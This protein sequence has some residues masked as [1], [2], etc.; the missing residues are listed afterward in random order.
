MGTD[1]IRSP[2]LLTNLIRTRE[3][4]L[5]ENRRIDELHI[6][7]SVIALVPESVARENTILPVD[8][9]GETLTCVTDRDTDV[10]LQDKLRFILNCNVR[11]LF[12]DRTDVIAGIVRYYGRASMTSAESYLQEFTDTAIDFTETAMDD[13]PMLADCLSDRLPVTAEVLRSRFSSL[14]QNVQVSPAIS[15]DG[16]MFYTIAEGQRILAHRR[17]GKVDVLQGPARVWKGFTRFERMRHY[18]AHPRQYLAIRFRD[19]REE[20]QLGPAELW[21]DPREHESIETHECLDLAAKE[22]VVVYNTPASDIDS[23]QTTRRIFYGPAQFAP[24]PGEWLHRFSWHAARGG[25]RGE[26]K[27]PDGLQF[28]KLCLMPD[29]MY[30]DVHDVR[31]ADD[32]VLT[33][34]LMIFFELVDIDRMLDTTHD[35]IGDFINA[36]TSDVVEFTGKRSF[37]SFK[38]HTEQ[39]N[40]LATYSQL[41][42]RAQ[43]CGYKINNVVYR[44]YGA[45]SSLQTMHDEAIQSRTRLRLERATE[46]Q[47][48]DVEDYKLTCQMERAE[49]RRSEQMTEVNHDLELKRQQHAADLQQRELEQDFQRDQRRSQQELELE[50]QQR[51]DEQKQSHLNSLR[52]LQVDL[53]EYLTQSRADQVIEVRGNANLTPEL[54]LANGKQ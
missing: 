51:Q 50:L 24:R 36:A 27:R 31:T 5:P 26:E 48:Q 47:A 46:E 42:H 52:E 12:S 53:T 16:F 41:L 10:M 4:R 20:I 35:P 40:E 8:F 32:A 13:E 21:H 22:A 44:G 54:H 9:D 1:L 15:G 2:G 30:H 49:R 3:F 23:D 34:R 14:Q 28:Q 33:I 45:P 38:Q 7:D 37:E 18:V 11:F 43:Q 19:G 29:Q 17:S 25:S 39:L 6:P